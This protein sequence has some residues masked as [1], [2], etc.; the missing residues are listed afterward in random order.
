MATASIP[1]TSPSTEVSLPI[2]RE[3]YS[4]I[5]H[6]LPKAAF[7]RVQATCRGHRQ[8]FIDTEKQ[9]ASIFIRALQEALK[10]A[11]PDQAAKMAPLIE[12]SAAPRK[13]VNLILLKINHE[14]LRTQLIYILSE[15]SSAELDALKVKMQETTPPKYFG[16][17]FQEV[18]QDY[19][20]NCE[21]VF[22][23]RRF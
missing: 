17:L 12:R 5:A 9:Q 18:Q 20:S 19:R 10:E 8:F 2:P 22:Q 1:S 21:I 4:R 6:F 15:F 11:H 16:D 13:S 3:V 14:L 23:A 7:E